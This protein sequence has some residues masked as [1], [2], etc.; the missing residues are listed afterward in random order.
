[1]SQMLAEI[2]RI[3]NE[4]VS[5]RVTQYDV[6]YEAITN[7]IHANA[8]KIIC[9]L[10]SF[11]NLLN[12]EEGNE[13]ADRKI[14]TIKVA[15]NGDGINDD[16]YNSFCKFRSNYK[17]KLGCKGVGRFTFLKVYDNAKY[18]SSLVSLQETR[19]FVFDSTFDTN[20]ITKNPEKMAERV[21]WDLSYVE[22]WTFFLDIKI[23]L[24]TVTQMLRG[25][26]KGA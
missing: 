1:M 13:I 12:D 8:T 7:S 4:D 5:N 16:N 3:I 22:N 15:D 26:M 20:N 19:S 21:K 17:I 2:E 23:I 9:T 14:D 18:K 25:K 6:L 10:N 24:I 11:D